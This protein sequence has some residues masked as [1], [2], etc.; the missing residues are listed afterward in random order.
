M[1]DNRRAEEEARLKEARQKEAKLAKK[2]E[3]HLYFE[4]LHDGS[5]G[6]ALI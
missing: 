4:G 1:E 3:N 2:V 5:I 6:S